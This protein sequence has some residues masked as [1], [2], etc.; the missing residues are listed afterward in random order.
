MARGGH[1][2]ASIELAILAGFK[3]AA[4]LCE[5]TNTD[6]TMARLPEIVTF[7]EQHDL[8]VVTIEDLIAVKQA[9]IETAA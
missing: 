3:P 8:P 9:R 4:V 5:I 7:G 1:T 6:G 2:E